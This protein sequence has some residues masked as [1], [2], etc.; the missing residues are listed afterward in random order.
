MNSSELHERIAAWEDLHTDF[1]LR[2]G[3]DRELAKDL[4]CFANTDG[5]QLVFGVSD[6]RQITGVDDTDWLASK[7]DDVAYQHCEPPITVVQE[8]IAAGSAKVLVVNVPKGDQR[9]YRTKSGHFY[10]RTTTGCRQ[11]SRE[12]LLRLFQ[13]SESF[14]YDESRLLRLSLADLDFDAVEQYL[15]DTEQDEHI[16]DAERLL[17]NWRLLEGEHPTVAGVVMFGRKPQTNLPQAQ[18][19]AATF[20][21]NDTSDNPIDR[22]DLTGRLLDVLGQAEEYL[23]LHLLN[24]HVIEGFESEPHPEVPLAAL[25][26]AVVNAVAHRDYTVSGPVRLFVLRDRVEIHTPGRAPN[27][28][29]EGAMRSGA[30]VVRNPHIYARLSDAGLVTRAGTGV[31]RIIRLVREATGR[32]VRID[33]QPHEVLVVIPRLRAKDS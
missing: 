18:I 29:D 20:A 17:R 27:T 8:T 12:E 2:F 23:R 30:H 5:G 9:P 22:T 28:V 3:S 16:D 14:Y 21:G 4:V 24:P 10:V 7:V 25:R 15:R 31:R 13:A 11:A 19:N 33:L 1:K 6:D 26:E 32:E